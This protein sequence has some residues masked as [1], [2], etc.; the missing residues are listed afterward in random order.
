MVIG[1]Y[2]RSGY[3]ID[4]TKDDT[5][6]IYRGRPGGVLWFDPTVDTETSLTGDELPADILRDVVSN[7]TLGSA[8]QA[9]KFLALVQ[10]AVMNATT[11]TVP[12]TTTTTG[13]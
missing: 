4:F 8:S 1:V 13:D 7:R 2:A 11:T 10:Q 12:S 9:A 5:V 6:A 3:F